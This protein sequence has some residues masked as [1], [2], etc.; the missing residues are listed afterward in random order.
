MRGRDAWAFKNPRTGP[1]LP[2]WMQV[3]ETLRLDARY[4]TVVRNPR[5]VVQSLQARNSFSAGFAYAL[6]TTNYL[7]T[8]RNLSGSEAVVVSYE[9]FLANPARKLRSIAD[10]LDLGWDQA[11]ES[12]VNEFATTF[13]SQD[14]NHF[15]SGL[16]V[17][18]SDSMCFPETLKLYNLLLA[19]CQAQDMSLP[20]EAIKKFE[21][22][23]QAWRGQGRLIE[24]LDAHEAGIASR[25]RKLDQEILSQH[26]HLSAQE[27]LIFE[28]REKSRALT[29]ELSEQSDQYRHL[30]N[31]INILKNDRNKLESIIEASEKALAS[32]LES[33]RW[34]TGNAIGEFKRKLLARLAFQDSARAY[35]FVPTGNGFC[36]FIKRSVINEI[37]VLDTENFPRGYGEE[38]D[39]CMRASEVGF[40]HLI[41]DSTY[42]LHR[43]GSSFNEYRNALMKTGIK[44]VNALH[45]NYDRLVAAAF[46]APALDKAR[47]AIRAA[48]DT[49]ATQATAVRP[50]VLFLA[51]QAEGG[52]NQTA[53]D[54][55]S[56]LASHYQA[57]ALLS[58]GKDITLLTFENDEL[59][60]VAHASLS[61]AIV[62]CRSPHPEYRQFFAEILQEFRIEMVH[63]H[64]LL[65]SCLEI[66]DVLRIF[67]IPFVLSLHDFFYVC[68][69]VNLLDQDSVYC[70]GVC[71]TGDGECLVPFQN[72]ATIPNLKHGWVMEWRDQLSE[73][74]DMAD[75]VVAPSRH[76][77]EIYRAAF[78]NLVDDRI[79]V[80]EHGRDLESCGDCARSPSPDAPARVL[81]PGVISRHKGAAYIQQLAML[82]HGKRLEFHFLGR[83]PPELE[84]VGVEHGPYE[85]SEFPD[86]ARGYWSRICR[87]IFDYRRDLRPCDDRSLGMRRS[88]AGSRY[89]NASR[90][91]GLQRR[92]VGFGPRRRECRLSQDFEN[93]RSP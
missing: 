64:H 25:L 47:N 5:N 89:R 19:Q 69:T 1:L 39:F 78:P 62:D 90:S 60:T 28:L 8:V 74:L 44:K 83:I 50:R 77:A 63:M 7:D 4:L 88:H 22:I 68:P 86:R 35:P 6:W 53:S 56:G 48:F 18:R 12:D 49:V 72:L 2:F 11:I 59:R 34:R 46:S 51:H 42:V 75:A 65:S 70:G 55:L 54:L 32:L 61:K 13:V 37:G 21:Q 9:D 24:S 43:E 80:I 40:H 15:K 45:P 52:M 76:V 87:A 14:L 33:S 27:R 79:T 31:A 58:D 17:L 10:R 93:L 3:F 85:V 81:V 30:N 41:D 16:S 66:C 20:P 29:E 71:T 92:R 38:N 26:E 23:D 84:G 82:D 73:L 67:D 91:R 36:L 57:Y